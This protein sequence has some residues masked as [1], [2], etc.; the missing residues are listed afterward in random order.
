ML[1]GDMTVLSFEEKA[2][3]KRFAEVEHIFFVSA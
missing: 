2:Q 1:S 3:I